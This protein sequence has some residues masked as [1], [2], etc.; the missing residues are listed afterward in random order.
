MISLNQDHDGVSL[1]K[2]QCII[3]HIQED[4]KQ[5][6]L[7]VKLYYKLSFKFNYKPLS[8]RVGNKNDL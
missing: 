1:P 7:D 3:H 6:T 8:E 5:N 4:Y 2:E